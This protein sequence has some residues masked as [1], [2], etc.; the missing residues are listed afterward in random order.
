[1]F[2]CPAV[3][4]FSLAILERVPLLGEKEPQVCVY[5]YWEQWL[6]NG[7]NRHMTQEG[8]GHRGNQQETLK[9]YKIF[10]CSY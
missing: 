2:F 8:P 7:E 5:L 10:F 9:K 6:H 1:M 3:N 4:H